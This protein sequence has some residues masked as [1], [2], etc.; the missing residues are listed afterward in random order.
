MLILENSLVDYIFLS[1]EVP[2]SLSILKFIKENRDSFSEITQFSEHQFRS[3]LNSIKR[4]YKIHLRNID[5]KV[6]SFIL[7][8]KEST[9]LKIEEELKICETNQIKCLSYF[10][11]EFPNLLRR[12][13]LPPKLIFMKG[14]IRDED[15]KAIAIIGSRNPTSY[16]KEMA[17]KIAKKFVELGFTIVSGFARGI[18]TIAIKAA[19]NNGGRAVGVIASGILNLYPPE[20]RYLVKQ[21]V[22]NGALISERFPLKSVNKRALQIRNRITS[23]S[24]R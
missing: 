1:R 23:L 22:N 8:K 24:F 18:D 15:E 4:N 20:N 21:L 12:I 17:E 7:K 19:L 11:E 9:F 10:D 16:G 5:V 13:K 3:F 14:N 2:L 6:S